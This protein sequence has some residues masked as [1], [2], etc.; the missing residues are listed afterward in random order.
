[1]ELLEGEDLAARLR[2][3]G[4]LSLKETARLVDH[5]TAALGAAHAR[6]I[7]H[8]DLKPENIFLCR[9]DGYTDWIEVL[10][11]GM[12]KV[13]TA[14]V[15][16]TSAGA[17]VGTPQFMSPEQALGKK[18]IDART[19]IFALGAVVYECL[20]GRMAFSGQT[21][22]SILE[23]VC[24]GT[25]VPIRE[26]NALVPEAVE[27]VV[28]RALEKKPKDRHQSVGELR[29]AFL[30]ASGFQKVADPLRTIPGV[31]PTPSTAPS[32][33]APAQHAADTLIDP[34]DITEVGL[35]GAGT[36]ELEKEIV[37]GP[38]RRVAAVIVVL[39]VVLGAG[40]AAL[41]L[42]TSETTDRR[43]APTTTPDSA[44]P[45]A[46]APTP[47]P[48]PAQAPAPPAP[49][50]APSPT[51]PPDAEVVQTVS[52]RLTSR[53]RRARVQRLE[54]QKYLGKTPLIIELPAGDERV[55]F[56]V[57]KRGYR[58]RTHWITPSKD[59]TSHARLRRAR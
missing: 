21:L 45:P 14:S 36:M 10:D 28:A 4:R 29:D 2:R 20:T 23:R 5:V 42:R 22:P 6:D 56:R 51:P 30:S 44:P 40:A 7:V 19:D 26:L 32:T 25:P 33:A 46:Q 35:A 15:K 8:R 24:K 11:F 9:Q 49:A 1:M 43:A 39:G 34:P 13:R 53:P 17:V 3:V 50:A 41:F 52:I 54:D 38:K 12:S 37:T 27:Q 57:R 18:H 31:V 47:A 16:L 59:Q 58:S 48:A 55:G